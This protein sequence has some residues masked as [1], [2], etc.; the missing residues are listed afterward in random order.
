M[1]IF[2]VNFWIL[3]MVNRT[4]QT[5]QSSVVLHAAVLRQQVQIS[6]ATG[7]SSTHNRKSLDNSMVKQWNSLL[8]N[9]IGMKRLIKMISIYAFLTSLTLLRPS[10]WWDQRSSNSRDVQV[11]WILFVP[12]QC[13]GKF[14]SLEDM[15]W[16]I[17]MFRTYQII[18]HCVFI[19]T[20]INRRREYATHQTSVMAWAP[21]VFG[22]FKGSSALSKNLTY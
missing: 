15:E 21:V 4:H 16:F 18:S 17:S 6:A 2:A 1:F 19:C 5:A 22:I 9:C 10:V 8:Y 12:P 20:F 14:F 3:H 13:Q 7:T 11:N